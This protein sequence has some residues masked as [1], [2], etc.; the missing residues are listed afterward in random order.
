MSLKFI[1]TTTLSLILSITLTLIS[2]E[3]SADSKLFEKKSRDG[4][5]VVTGNSNKQDLKFYIDDNLIAWQFD[6]AR[7]KALYPILFLDHDIDNAAILGMSTDDSIIVLHQYQAAK[8]NIVEQ[9]ETLIDAI[10][11]FSYLGSDYFNGKNLNIA[12]KK[13]SRWIGKSEQSF[14]Y[15]TV[16]LRS[17]KLTPKL[18]KTIKSK[19]TEQGAF[20]LWVPLGAYEKHELFT[21][22]DWFNQEFDGATYWYSNINPLRSD[23]LMLGFKNQKPLTLDTLRKKSIYS[24]R[25]LLEQSNFYSLLSF[26]IT[27]G[28]KFNQAKSSLNDDFSSIKR[29]V[30]YKHPNNDA[31]YKRSADNFIALANYR[32]DSS[33]LFNTPDKKIVDKL[34][35]YFDARSSIIDGQ[36][37]AAKTG[38]VNDQL[39]HYD[40]AAKIVSDE[41]YLGFCY[42]SLGEV[43]YRNRLFDQAV[44]LLEKSRNANQSNPMIRTLLGLAYEK[45]LQYNKASDEF[46]AAKKIDPNY[47][48]IKI[49]TTK[50][51]SAH[52]PIK[53]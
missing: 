49:G 40:K 7:R 19:L 21:I 26:Y 2:Y 25:S 44:S 18:I 37:V 34:R 23:I 50:N 28:N 20:A 8:V 45:T 51:K 1:F 42:Y 29:R 11:E 14:D 52:N 10:Q 27:D 47:S 15:I 31:G 9:N 17:F 24:Q 36:M 16:D 48:Y 13:P 41:P 43:Y 38:K 4:K 30:K 5:V 22:I 35:K 3:A 32:A 6:D 46:A 39:V 33:T 12:L 53:P